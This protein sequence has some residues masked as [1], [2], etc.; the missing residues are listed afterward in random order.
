LLKCKSWLTRHL[1]SNNKKRP[2]QMQALL[3]I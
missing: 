2:L 3:I 1:I